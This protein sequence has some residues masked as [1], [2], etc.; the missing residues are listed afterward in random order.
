VRLL[1]ARL[2]AE[3][4]DDRSNQQPITTLLATLKAP[5]FLP[6]L[7]QLAPRLSPSSTIVLLHNGLGV[8][9]EL[10]RELWPDAAKRPT[11][12]QGITSA[13]VRTVEPFDVRLEGRGA[14]TFATVPAAGNPSEPTSLQA[15]TGLLTTLAR[16]PGSLVTPRV[17]PFLELQQAAYLK[18][19]VNVAINPLTAL[20]G[21]PNGEL[22]GEAFGPLLD[23]LVGETS[24][25][26]RAMKDADG[27]PLLAATAFSAKTLKA[28]ILDVALNTAGNRSSMLQDVDAGR[29]TEVDYISGHLSGIAT[30][31]GKNAPL[32]ALLRQ[33]V[34]SLGTPD[35]VAR[36]LTAAGLLREFESSSRCS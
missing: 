32:N 14:W 36:P 7:R 6:A 11:L 5:A 24:T 34:A 35:A 9:E 13:G 15:T 29:P 1:R 4:G 16:A 17:V 26:L 28:A 30:S 12:V 2:D 18:M 31:T 23:L 8:R 3:A 33:K 10:I 25:V 20:F 22:A 21:V 19:A 27:R